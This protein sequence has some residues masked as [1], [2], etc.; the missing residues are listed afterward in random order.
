ME[1]QRL[2]SAL[3]KADKA[4]DVKAAT[5]IAREIRRLQSQQ[6]QAD[7]AQIAQAQQDHLNQMARDTGTLESFAIGAGRGLSNFGRGA[8][9]LFGDL[10]GFEDNLLEGETQTEKAALRALKKENPIP[11]T[12]GEIIGEIAPAVVLPYGAAAKATTTAGRYA[13]TAALGALEGA[14]LA[15][16]SD[17]DVKTGALLGGAGAGVGLYVAPIVE[18]G[19]RKIANKL[20]FKPG[21]AIDTATGQPTKDFKAALENNNISIDDIIDAS[22]VGDIKDVRVAARKALFES[23][24]IPAT[25]GDILGASPQGFADQATEAR[26]FESAQDAVAADMREFRLQ[27]S[28]TIKSKIESV[29]PDN[30]VG[31]RIGETVKEALQDE[32]KIITRAKNAFYKQAA[33]NAEGIG[34]IPLLTDD[35]AAAIADPIQTRRLKRGESAAAINE[36]ESLLAE[37]GIIDD[38]RVLKSLIDNDPDFEVLPLDISNFD[39]LRQG[40]L[41]IQRNDQ[42]GGASVY[43]GDIITALDNEADNAAQRIGEKFPARVDII[44]PLK[45]ARQRVKQLKTEFSDNAIAGKLIRTQRDGFTPFIEASK[46]YKNVVGTNNAPEFIE[47]LSNTLSRSAS[48]G[49]ENAAMAIKDMQAAA[50]T[51]LLDSGFGTLS[52]RVGDEIIFNPNAFIRRFDQIGSRKFKAIFGEG[53]DEYKRVMRMRKIAEAMQLPD[54]AK[55]KG[56]GNV[57]LDMANKLG[58]MTLSS[59]IPIVGPLAEGWKVVS[60]RMGARTQLKKALS[61]YDEQRVG[62]VQELMPRLSAA[63]AENLNKE[64]N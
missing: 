21:Q 35:L 32:K 34:G 63:M 62:L 15:R 28:N 6:S 58:I 61:G 59:K 25:R 53:T 31:E 48:R 45:E 29:L 8:V 19:V 4:G 57:V 9:N 26:L 2:E 55:P 54:G 43:L 11:S 22:G 47:R 10:L 16:G 37:F 18:R 36:A 12:A 23:E 52:R 33:D 40:L 7:Q 46:V 38:E 44:Q 64:E 20:G 27:Q 56:S 13:G 60:E 14:A 3:R 39:E 1:I 50:I 49:N 17:K 51:D 42:T 24:N 30:S 5:I 41:R